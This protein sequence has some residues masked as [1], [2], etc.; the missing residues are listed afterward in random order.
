V[1]KRFE[2]IN[3]K[4]EPADFLSGRDVSNTPNHKSYPSRHYLVVERNVLVIGWTGAQG[5]PVVKG[6]SAIHF[7]DS[8]Q[9]NGTPWHLILSIAWACS[10]R[11]SSK[12][13]KELAKTHE[14][15]RKFL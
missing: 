11:N 13:A 10:K 14:G 5:I 3:G 9:L 1:H 7:S 15:E 2:L 4:T 6:R 8:C 12:E